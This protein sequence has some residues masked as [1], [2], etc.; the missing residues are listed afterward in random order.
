MDNFTFRIG[1][2]SV[3]KFD[4]VHQIVT[5]KSE[6]LGSPNINLISHDPIKNIFRLDQTME[7]QLLRAVKPKQHALDSLVNCRS[8]NTSLKSLVNKFKI[9]RKFGNE[10]HK[11]MWL[12][13][14]ANLSELDKLQQDIINAIAQD[15]EV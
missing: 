5:S 2:E 1:I 10:K 8:Y 11:K 15:V 12:K 6:N 7:W 14:T 9:R 13:G 3:I 4:S